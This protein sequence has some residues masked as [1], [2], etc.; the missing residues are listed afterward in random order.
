MADQPISY[1]QIDRADS[2]PLTDGERT[3]LGTVDGFLAKGLQL[4]RWWDRVDATNGYADRF[5]LTQTLYRPN[6]SFGFFD[7]A[8]I[9]GRSTPVAGVVQDMFFDQPKSAAVD[10]WRSEVRE[11]VL[12]YFM[13]ISDFQLPEPYV[14]SARASSAPSP[15]N[16]LSWCPE[17]NPE[18]EGFGYSQLY[19]KLSDS[20][21][22]GKFPSAHKDAIV[23]VREMGDKYEWIILNAE[24]YNLDFEIK[25]FGSEYPYMT[26]PLNRLRKEGELLILHRDFITYEDRPDEEGVVG[27]YGLGYA[28]MVD[29]TTEGTIFVSGPG[30]L[31]FGF[32]T[33][34]FRVLENG[35]TYV[36]MPLV[37]YRP[38]KL[39]EL[40]FNPADWV[41]RFSN[42]VAPDKGGGL[43]EP[44]KQT[45]DQLSPGISFDP[46]NAFIELANLS[47]GGRAAKQFCITK[48]QL[49]KKLMTWHFMANYNL[50]VGLLQTWR[51]IPDWLDADKLPDWVVTGISS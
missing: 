45:F 29:P 23:D 26:L 1:D 14:E 41:A 50:F 16:S 49:D 36:R 22:I 51:Q 42:L 35:E 34:V 39:A 32:Q 17:Q 30:N 24:L 43:L 2:E 4:K 37:V 7:R 46:F 25:P 38:A 11:F 44:L 47:S 8:P 21:R 6:N 19:Y 48:D 31:R 20:G 13:R 10:K 27:K 28:T 3:L 9:D 40:S 12:R 5:K 15:F 18:L 33:F